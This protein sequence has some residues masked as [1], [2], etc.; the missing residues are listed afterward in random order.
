ML[1]QG[2]NSGRKL[3]NSALSEDE[4]CVLSVHRRHT[5]SG[6]PHLGSLINVRFHWEYT[7]LC[8][9]VPLGGLD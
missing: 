8:F 5:L 4:V 3:D 2:S 9:A 7:D 6:H 1:G